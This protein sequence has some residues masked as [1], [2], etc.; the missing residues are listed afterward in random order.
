MKVIVQHS[1]FGTLE[2]YKNGGTK[3]VFMAK[4]FKKSSTFTSIAELLQ[5]NVSALLST[6]FPL[7]SC[8]ISLKK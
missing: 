4:L 2:L 5:L 3:F 6:S 1:L 7:F 8:F